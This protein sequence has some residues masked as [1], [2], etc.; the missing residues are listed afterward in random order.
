MEKELVPVIA[1]VEDNEPDIF[2]DSP[3][4]FLGY[5]NELGE[6]FRPL[7]PLWMVRATYGIAI[8]YAVADTIDKARKSYHVGTHS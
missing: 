4:R 2:K 8:T 6:S 7:I 3:L 1:L 5:T